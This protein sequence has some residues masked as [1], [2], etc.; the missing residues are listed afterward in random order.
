M[1]NPV[2]PS[3]P[4]SVVAVLFSS[5]TSAVLWLVLTTPFV[6]GALYNDPRYWWFV[7]LLVCFSLVTL[8]RTWLRIRAEKER[9]Q[10]EKDRWL[11]QELEQ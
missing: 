9:E 2:S 6:L 8:L 10:E 4:P 11:A 1:T 7:A 3:V 5:Y